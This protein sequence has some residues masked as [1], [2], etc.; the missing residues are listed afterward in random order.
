MKKVV[1]V[2]FMDDC[3]KAFAVEEGSSVEQ[4]KATVVEKIGMKA[5]GCFAIFERKDGWG[6]SFVLIISFIK[7]RCLESDEKPYELMALWTDNNTTGKAPAFV[8]KKKIFLRDDER[9][10]SDLIAKHHVYIQ[11]SLFDMVA[12]FRHCTV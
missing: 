5:D 1:R 12:N 11:V 4:L 9:E 2:H 8:F 7:E 10:M 6:N 3:I